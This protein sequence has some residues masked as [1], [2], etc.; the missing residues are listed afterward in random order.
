MT[1]RIHSGTLCKNEKKLAPSK[2]SNPSLIKFYYKG[3]ATLAT[4][5]AVFW[6]LHAV[7]LLINVITCDPIAVQNLAIK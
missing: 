3:K 7:R 6:L 2:L 5:L 4:G 1:I